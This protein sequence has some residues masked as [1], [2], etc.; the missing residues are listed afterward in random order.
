M[1]PGTVKAPLFPPLTWPQ[2]EA[3]WKERE[4]HLLADR[5]AAWRQLSEAHAQRDRA[6]AEVRKLKAE[7]SRARKRIAELESV[8]RAGG[9]TEGDHAASKQALP[10]W[11]KPDV[12]K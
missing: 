8:H 3:A 9:D 2:R 10:P 7:L 4:H 5:N 1:A 6:Q 12:A 11:V